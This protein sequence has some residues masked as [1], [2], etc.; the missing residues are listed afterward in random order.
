[1]IVHNVNKSIVDLTF[2]QCFMWEGQ[3]VSHA[4]S[5][6]FISELLCHSY[7]PAQDN[8]PAE[9]FYSNSELCLNP[10]FC[11]NKDMIRERSR[12]NRTSS[13]INGMTRER[14]A[15]TEGRRDRYGASGEHCGAVAHVTATRRVSVQRV[16]REV[17]K[18]TPLQ[19]NR[20][21][22]SFACLSSER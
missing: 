9:H 11:R 7:Q 21:Y 22:L 13:R 17:N 10:R 1:M 20:F 15:A 2:S 19:R 14:Q 18:A 8:I 16:G 5:Y 6:H 3:S 4:P 12:T